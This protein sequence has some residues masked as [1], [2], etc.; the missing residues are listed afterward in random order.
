MKRSISNSINIRR[1]YL[2]VIIVG[3]LVLSSICFGYSGGSGTAEEPYRIATKEDLLALAETTEDYNKC[4]ILTADINMGG[5]V[6]TTAIIASDMDN[7]N[8]DFDGTVFTGVFDGAG[9]KVLNLTIDTNG[10]G[11]DYLG[12][13]G[14][15]GV[16]G[17]V[18]NLG[19]ENVEVKGGYNPDRYDSSCL[20][21][22]AGWN[23]GTISNCYSKGTV[24]GGYDSVCLGGLV[25]W[26]KSG[27]INDC[28]SA[29]AVSGGDYSQAFGGLVGWNESGSI[30]NSYSMGIIAGNF[31]SGGLVGEND[32]SISNSYSM[33]VVTGNYY[34]GGLVGDNY[35]GNISNCYSTGAVDGGNYSAC[36]GGLVGWNESGSIS[37]CYSRDAVSGGNYSS[38]LGGLVG[39]N[40]SGSISNCYSIGAVSGGYDSHFL[41]GLVGENGGSISDCYFLDTAG[42]DNGAGIPLTDAQ[43]KQQSSFVGW[44]FVGETI[45][46]P[47]DI[48]KICEGESYPQLRYEKYGGGL[49]DANNPYLIYTSC[50]MD[51]IGTDANDWD[52]NFKLM[53]DIDLGGYSGTE[54]NIIGKYVGYQDPC[55]RPFTGVFDGNGH[56]ISNFTYS[57]DGNDVGIFAY[58]YRSGVIKDLGLIDPNIEGGDY[59]GSLVG[60]HSNGTIT[61]CYVKGGIVRGGVAVG[62]LTG[63]SY[64]DI[65]RCYSA[66]AVMGEDCVGGLAGVTCG[67]ASTGGPSPI[68]APG[69]PAKITDCYSRGEVSGDMGVGGLV[70]W[71]YVMGGGWQ[72]VVPAKITNCYSVGAV[73]GNSHVGGLIG[74]NNGDVNNC[75][76]D[77]NSS[78]QSGSSGGTGKTTA[79]MQTLSTFTSAGWDFVGE[80]IN[81]P[82]DIWDICDGKNYPKLSWQIPLAGDFVCPDG[83][84]FIDFAI[85]ANAWLS[86]PAQA[87]WNGRCDIAEPIDNV[88]NLLDL[89]TF[90]QNWLE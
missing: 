34:S 89:E 66:T 57:T 36:L 45:N 48:W 17:E 15:I 37:N 55:S 76:W 28:Y 64:N 31:S 4:F 10:V 88:I 78:G 65:L 22:L 80:V 11:N 29:G 47:N 82:N 44:D 18:K 30:S 79:E 16:G 68:P 74:N 24:T 87:N 52:K 25:G 21:G 61:N 14:Y 40:D 39:W 3:G 32:G 43:M 50:Q 90:A 72:N 54:F 53:A 23:D 42:P 86:D 19:L 59:V 2:A 71:N 75:F 62:G 8:Y 46:G 77:V 38:D 9:H 1:G 26:N 84:N 63:I 70:G 12:L 69:D 27:G 60:R 41:G 6:F 33:C 56:T 58:V 67:Y 81:G 73:S 83:V 35:G 13:F 20:G 85:L 7:S 51:T 49:G 5:Q